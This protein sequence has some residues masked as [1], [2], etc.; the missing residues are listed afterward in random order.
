M[1][2]Q[3][4][5]LEGVCTLC[6]REQEIQVNQER[7]RT[8]KESGAYIQDALPELTPGEREFLISGICE[9]CFDKQFGEE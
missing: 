8:W 1:E 2:N 7:Y 4:I 5:T 6:G 3:R 9:K